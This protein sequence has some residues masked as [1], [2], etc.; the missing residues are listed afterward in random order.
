MR[1]RT[2]PV[3]RQGTDTDQAPA[4]S[5]RVRAIVTQRVAPRFCTAT[6]SPAAAAP[7]ARRTSPEKRARW[8]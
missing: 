4:S 8:P 7:S 1:A 5:V 3:L 6:R 2:W